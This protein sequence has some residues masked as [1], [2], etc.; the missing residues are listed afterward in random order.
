MTIHLNLLLINCYIILAGKPHNKAM[1]LHA[2]ATLKVIIGTTHTDDPNAVHV[3]KDNNTIQA[4]GKEGV[5]PLANGNAIDQSER[6]GE[7]A[8]LAMESANQNTDV[9]SGSG[10]NDTKKEEVCSGGEKVEW[11]MESISAVT[12]LLGGNGR[13]IFY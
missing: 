10:D 6:N 3:D 11:C 1:H 4:N 8:L 5:G 12:K 2:I 7:G 9:A 13:I